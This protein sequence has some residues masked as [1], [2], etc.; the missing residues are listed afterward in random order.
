M[1]TYKNISFLWLILIAVGCSD[2]L[3]QKPE[4]NL[5]PGQF[6]RN[7]DD[8]KS[9]ISAV[10]DPLNSANMYN[11][12]MWVIQDQSTDDSEW[13]G[14]RSTA[15]QAKNDLDKYTF[16]PQ[17]STFYSV[18]STCYQAINRANTAIAHIPSVMMDESLKARLI[19]EAK[20]MRGFYY[21]T[22]VRLFGEIPIVL[23]ETN[24]LDN[25]EVARSTVDE[26]YAQ[27]IQDFQEA[28]SILPVSYTAGDK[29]RATQGAAK[30]F[31]AK[32]YLTREEWAKASAKAKEVIDLNVYD[33]WTN[34]ADAFSIAN[35]NGKES[36]FEIQAI[37]GGFNEGSFMQGYMRPPFARVN[38]VTGFGDVPPTQNLYNAYR[39]K[40]ARR[41][42][43]LKLYSATT[44]PAAPAS[45]AFPCYVNKYLDGTATANGDGGNNFPIIRYPDVLLMYA[46]ALNEQTPNHPEAYA[47]INKVRKRAG[48]LDLTPD[49]TQTQF[50]DSVLLERRLELAFEGHRRY[51]LIRTKRLI[52]AMAQQN[53]A[54]V[55]QEHHYLFPIP[56]TERDV[57]IKLTQNPGY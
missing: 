23:D 45:I 6:Y 42:V 32:V 2:I 47:A 51:D 34:F 9:A 50:K 21:F 41:D 57:N 3:D 48:L 35:E 4:S 31:L 49:L 14:G 12:V 52:Q 30:A 55:V 56:Q 40:D 25:L 5:S 27:I 11:Q 20:F 36:V 33:L 38:G 18:W 44:T 10:Y 37:G 8:A 17:T 13:G 15:N 7:G 19:A 53:P 29:G 22:L 1:K 39:S 54:I 43:T 24:S 26:V 46:E 28:E 16:T